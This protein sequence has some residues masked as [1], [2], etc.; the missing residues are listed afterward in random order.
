MRTASWRKSAKSIGKPMPPDLLG[1]A[2]GAKKAAS[3]FPERQTDTGLG[4]ALGGPSP[5]T[6]P[7]P[8]VEAAK[9]V[10][11]TAAYEDA[12]G[13]IHASAGSKRAGE[14][15]K[16]EIDYRAWRATG[17]NAPIHTKVRP[18][19]RKM[20]YQGAAREEK[21]LCVVLEEM[22]LARYGRKK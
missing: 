21:E 7:E 17:R 9:T 14:A 2:L 4:D 1:N 16:N 15:P 10:R 20:F 18:E 13:T 19:Y 8:I 22:I 6:A 11:G 3:K 12:D 5:N